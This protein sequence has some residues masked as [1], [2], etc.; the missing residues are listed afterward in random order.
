MLG[1][2]IVSHSGKLAEGV[3]D[4]V[5]MLAAEVPVVAAGGLEDGSFGTSFDKITEAVNAVYSPE[6]VILFCDMG[7]ALLTAE[8]VLEALPGLRLHLARSPLVEGALVAG[9]AS[10]ANQDLDA[11]IL[12]LAADDAFIKN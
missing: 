4:L 6:G 11:T 3:V 9:M 2:V 10:I 12:E 5:K 7:S 8:M 1:I